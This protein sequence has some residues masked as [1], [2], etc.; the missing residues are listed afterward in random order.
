[1]HDCPVAAGD[2]FLARRVPILLRALGPEGYLVL[3]W[4]EGA[5]DRGCCGGSSGGHIATVVAGP[6]VRR[7]ARAGRP[8]DH[9]GVLGTIEDT[10]GL[11]RLGAA[12]DS[13]H[14]SLDALFSRRPRIRPAARG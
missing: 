6:L 2:R 5:S 10:L 9:Y 4:D 14:G 12:A 13:A 1:M 8:V 3:T 11:P 7:G